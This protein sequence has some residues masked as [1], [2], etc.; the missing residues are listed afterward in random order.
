MGKIILTEKEK[1]IIEAMGHDLYTVAYIEQWINRNDNVF[2]NA[3]AALNAMAAK[4][5]Y[6]A[7]KKATQLLGGD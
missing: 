3:P 6:E 4:G 1:E 5:Y 2:V 7:V